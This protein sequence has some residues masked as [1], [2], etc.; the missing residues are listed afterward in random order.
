M[1]FPPPS[2]KPDPVP[3]PPIPWDPE[4]CISLGFEPKPG[5]FKATYG[6]VVVKAGYDKSFVKQVNGGYL[7]GLVD[8]YTPLNDTIACRPTGGSIV[9]AWNEEVVF[10]RAYVSVT[11]RC[12]KHFSTCT[13]EEMHTPGTWKTTYYS[14][15]YQLTIAFETDVIDNCLNETIVRAGRCSYMSYRKDTGLLQ[16]SDYDDWPSPGAPTD[17][18]W[19]PEIGFGPGDP[20]PSPGDEEEPVAPSVRN[21]RVL[22]A[23]SPAAY[24]ARNQV[25]RYAD[26][27]AHCVVVLPYG[28]VVARA[29]LNEPSGPHCSGSMCFMA[30]YNKV[31][32][33]QE[34]YEL[35]ASYVEYLR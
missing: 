30:Y 15:V 6:E 24:A 18:P 17:I 7:T 34:V 19:P 21:V 23:T 1:I 12:D 31:G 4:L 10:H 29:L 8:A 28:H 2:K 14:V 32:R 27:N 35:Y 26:Y 11:Q 20:E 16:C 33:A 3:I 5:L 13:F 9:Q 25:L 22:V